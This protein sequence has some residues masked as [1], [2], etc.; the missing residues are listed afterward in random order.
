MTVHRPKSRTARTSP[1]IKAKHA[2]FVF[3][4]SAVGLRLSESG[5]KWNNV[6]ANGYSCKLQYRPTWNVRFANKDFPMYPLQGSIR[7]VSGQQGFQTPTSNFCFGPKTLSI[8]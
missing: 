1:S 5:A 6:L 7:C 4:G 8:S 2:A 3:E